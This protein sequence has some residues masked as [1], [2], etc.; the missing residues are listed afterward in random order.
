MFKAAVVLVVVA[1]VYL[2]WPQYV[3]LEKE[4]SFGDDYVV[5]ETGIWSKDDCR[6]AGK[7]FYAGYKCITTNAWQGIL[8]SGTEYKRTREY[9]ETERK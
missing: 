7:R 3:L 2:F 6:A 9:T 5:R 8:G 4:S 1:I